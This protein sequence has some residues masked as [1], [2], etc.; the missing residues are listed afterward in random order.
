MDTKGSPCR[1]Q[2]GMGSL[3]LRKRRPAN[4]GVCGIT[5]PEEFDD[6]HELRYHETILAKAEPEGITPHYLYPNFTGIAGQSEDLCCKIDMYH[7]ASHSWAG[8]EKTRFHEYR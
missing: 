3:L 1:L 7:P 8:Q 2:G 4:R 6:G 5:H